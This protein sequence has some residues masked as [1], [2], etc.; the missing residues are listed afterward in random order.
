MKFVSAE[1]RDI[2]VTEPRR[3]IV[4]LVDTSLG[5]HGTPHHDSGLTLMFPDAHI[6]APRFVTGARCAMHPRSLLA[7]RGARFAIICRPWQRQHDRQLQA[8]RPGSTIYRAM[9]SAS[10]M[11]LA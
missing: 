2:N 11:S 8:R 9:R 7:A 1:P 3:Y 4:T 6:T 10:D 5:G